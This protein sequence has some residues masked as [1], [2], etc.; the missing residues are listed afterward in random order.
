MLELIE[1]I[2]IWIKKKTQKRSYNEMDVKYQMA[3]RGKKM[4]KPRKS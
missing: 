4:T 3:S 2:I 1:T